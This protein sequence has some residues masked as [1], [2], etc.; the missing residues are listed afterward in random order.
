[1]TAPRVR[2][3]PAPS[4]TMHVG[5]A[6]T[7]LYNWLHARGNDGTFVLR[8]EDTD[9]ERATDAAFAATLETLRWL[10]LDWDEGPDE[11]AG[12]TGPYGPYRQ[13]ARRPLHEAVA[14][15]LVAGGHAY[16]A[17]E[18]AE[19]LEAERERAQAEGRTPGYQGGHRELTQ[20]QKQVFRAEGR[21]PV[22]RL[23]TPDSGEVTFH[24]VV[25]GPVT[26]QW[27][28]V[29]DFVILRADRSPTYPLAAG[30]DDL[31]MGITFVA[32][33]EDLLAAT[34]RQ[35]LL[36]E[37]L[38][39]DEGGTS[40]LAGVLADTGFPPRPD[41]PRPTYAHLPL[42]V[43]ED[44]KPLSKRHGSVAVDEFRRQGFL[45][46]VLC[47]FLALCGWSY[48]ATTERFTVPELVERFSF[49]RVGKNPAFFDTDKL[50]ALNGDRIKELDGGEL[51]DRLVPYL[52]AEGLIA[53][54]PTREERRL[55][56]DLVPL[57]QERIQTL[58]EAAPLIAFCFADR[59][60]Y[61]EKAVDK[62]LRKGRADE[63]LEAAERSLA[64][65]EPWDADTIMASLDGVAERLGLG[66]GK[67]FQP[68]RVAVAGT[69]VSPPL[70]ET[71]AVLDRALVLARMRE[72]QRLAASPAG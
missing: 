55:L 52:A 58:A 62:H 33:G 23:R 67:T 69:P 29:P 45:P 63:V 32:R 35:M 34:P 49:D 25:R 2:F 5:N 39:A 9:A 7:A 53:E 66:R 54:P 22:I 60:E 12:D 30:V 8:V 50:R 11:G 21:E 40:L 24:D 31:A 3:A 65:V 37:A 43:G 27:K 59:V 47:N 68:V 44:R 18:T 6:R 57:L 10:G 20:E 64:E 17:F 41:V 46:E 19:E 61:D 16:E 48:D 26:F 14:D 70:P 51:A 28:D 13:S 38:L 36:A 72:A 71:L 4:G 56:G 1:M 42:L 15:A